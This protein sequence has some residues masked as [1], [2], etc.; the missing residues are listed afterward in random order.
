[1]QLGLRFRNGVRIALDLGPEVNARSVGALIQFAG[2]RAARRIR[3][4]ADA[5]AQRTT[6]RM[7]ER[8]AKSK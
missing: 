7:R 1:M 4:G 3:Q 8:K 5:A 6:E 2:A